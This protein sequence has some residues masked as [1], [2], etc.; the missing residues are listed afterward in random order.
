MVG[1]GPFMF[2]EWVVGDHVTVVKNPNYWDTANAAHLDQITFKPIG[3][4]TAKLQALQAG[5]VDLAFSISPP[6]VKTAQS[7]G[8]TIIDRGAVL[9]PV[10]PGHRTRASAASRPIYANKSVRLA[11]AE[12]VNKQSYIDA[13]YA[14]PG[15]GPDR[16]HAAGHHRLQGRDPADLRRHQGQGRSAGRRPDRR[17]AQ[18]RPL[19]PVQRRSAVHA[20]SQGHGSG[21]RPGSPGGRLHGHPQDRGLARRLRQPTPP[22]ASSRST[23]S[24]GPATGPAPTTSSTP[25]G[26]ATQ[27]ASRTRSSAGRTPRPTR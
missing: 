19:L 18:H 4:S 3:D 5:G 16:L 17:P 27:A 23:S 7:S 9:Q 13:F 10:Q 12:A 14:R 21:H 24:A 22:P 1:T 6:D 11:I 15:Q 20:R 2:K 8:L 26:S 25:P